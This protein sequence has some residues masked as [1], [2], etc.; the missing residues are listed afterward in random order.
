MSYLNRGCSSILLYDYPNVRHGPYIEILAVCLLG[1]SM[2][3][4][5]VHRAGSGVRA[6]VRK[7]ESLQVELH[8]SYSIHR[9]NSMFKYRAST[10]IL[11]A[12]VVLLAI[13]LIPLVCV[14]VIDAIPMN[15]PDLGLA[16]SGTVWMRGV[17]VGLVNSFTLSWMFCQY[18]PELKLSRRT[19]LSTTIAATAVSHLAVL[20][21]I[22][23]FRYPLPFTLV[24]MSGPW[25][26]TLALSLKLSRGDFLSKNPA[27]WQDVR[28]FSILSVMHT[29]SGLIITGFNSVPEEWQTITALL[30]P[31]FKITERNLFCRFLRGK[32]DLKPE[33]VVFTVEITN[34]LFISTSM[35]QAAST[36]TSA[37]LILID[38]VQLLISLCDLSLMLKS[39]KEITDKMK[40]TPNEIIACA[41]MLSTNYPELGK[42][43]PLVDTVAQSKSDVFRLSTF[44]KIHAT[45]SQVGRKLTNTNRVAPT[46]AEG[47]NMAV[48]PS[49][50]R[51]VPVERNSVGP[52]ANDLE[53]MERIT[54]RERQML[55]RKALQI[56]FL[57][58][59]LLLNE[60]MEV[61]TPMMYMI[62]FYC[63]NREF[64]PLFDGLD[65][66]A[67]QKVVRNIVVY[68]LLELG[69]FVLLVVIIHRTTHKFP[70]QQLAYAVSGSWGKI[71]CKLA[72]WLTLLLQSTIPQLGA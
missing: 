39:V 24:W 45:A 18:V 8:G 25:I 1:Q 50:S 69:S 58:E 2:T 14:A 13:P 57:T 65:E 7:W 19:L 59:F 72:I 64:Y 41:F 12:L 22:M 21:L 3:T 4:E 34:T 40:I 55:L 47:G 53:L 46:L 15:S 43:T 9:F 16:G 70:F 28:R 60:L 35:Q 51:M 30:V 54:P 5:V 52:T 20:G 48:V 17:S 31:A 71:E 37:V 42:E 49:T 56:L 44:E 23:M 32:D 36:K 33:L 10:G 68:G 11:R 6:L 66:A 38:F 67:F 29:S 62:L 26:A 27:V 61:L 63:P